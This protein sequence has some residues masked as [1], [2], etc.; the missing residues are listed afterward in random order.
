MTKLLCCG[1]ARNCKDKLQQNLLKINE[2][3]CRYFDTT[4][5]IY[6]NDSTD[7]TKDTLKKLQA[8]KS[9]KIE[10]ISENLY[11]EKF[12]DVDTSFNRVKSMCQFRNKYLNFL[13][14]NQFDYMLVVDWD[15]YDFDVRK[16][17]K[18]IDT[19]EDFD[20]YGAYGVVSSS[21]PRY[22]DTWSLEPNKIKISE[23]DKTKVLSCFS[24]IGLY[25]LSP[26]FFTCKYKPIEERKTGRKSNPNG[27][28]NQLHREMRKVGL[29]RIYVNPEIKT[30]WK[31][32]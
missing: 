14:N 32:K 9:L 29:D 5:F 27:D 31:E 2:Q 17:L 10:Y 30:W 7:G 4:F 25:K 8:Q 6:E 16:V 18:I 26:I 1:L 15:L 23:K 13:N 28:H 24:G 19:D 20:M 21:N 11:I 12:S 22:Y 3:V